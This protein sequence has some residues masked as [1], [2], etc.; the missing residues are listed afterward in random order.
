MREEYQN[1]LN[2]VDTEAVIADHRQFLEKLLAQTEGATHVGKVEKAEVAT[3]IL[4][5]TS[6]SST[7]VESSTVPQEEKVTSSLLL[8]VQE[9]AQEPVVSA[10]IEESSKNIELSDLS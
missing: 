2:Q 5:T 8:P 1:E 10:N 3:P 4:D 6:T 7:T 9:V